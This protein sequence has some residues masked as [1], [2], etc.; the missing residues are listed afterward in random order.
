[1]RIE[2]SD[3]DNLHIPPHGNHDDHGRFCECSLLLTG[4]A[5][6]TVQRNTVAGTDIRLLGSM[7][8]SI[9]LT[10]V[11]RSCQVARLSPVVMPVAGTC[12]LMLGLSF[13]TFSTAGSVSI[14]I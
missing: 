2:K 5:W 4:L 7:R 6:H 3:T 14:W 9:S 10:A 11:A 8:Q 13:G 12:I 1:M